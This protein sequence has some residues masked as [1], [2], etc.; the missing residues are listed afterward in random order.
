[1]GIRVHPIDGQIFLF[2][3]RMLRIFFLSHLVRINVETP[4]GHLISNGK[5]VRL[6]LL[7]FGPCSAPGALKDHDLLV[8]YQL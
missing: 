3:V 5:T 6:A 7:K 1:M 2:F 4:F 8:K